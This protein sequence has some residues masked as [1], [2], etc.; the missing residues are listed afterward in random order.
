MRPVVL[1]FPGQGAQYVGMGQNLEPEYQ[2]FFYKADE[3]LG[4]S[5]SELCFKGPAESLKLTEN[6]QPALLSYSLALFTKLQIFLESQKIPVYGVLGHSVGEYSALVAASALSFEDAIRLVHLR[7]KAMQSA[8]PVGKGKMAA[9][10]RVEGDLVKSACLSASS[11]TE[12][13]V[14]ANF[15]APDQ[16][17]ISGDMNA[18]NRAMEIIKTQSGGKAR[19]IELEVS[20]PFHSPLML[21]ASEVMKK[22]LL[23]TKIHPNH[24]PYI[25]NVDAKWYS[26]QTEPDMIRQNLVDQV[27]QSVLWVQSIEKLPADAICVEVGPGKVLKGLVSKI[28]PEC[29]VITMESEN[30]LQELGESVK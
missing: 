7:G 22:A 6:T 18:V 21:P 3:I 24:L 5:L 12:V 9:I 15:N 20:A 11:E 27:A 2:R 26:A 1:L 8:V 13:V 23:E 16:V 29:L 10:L 28:R 19:T 25:A 30:A 4:Y 14:P 17:V